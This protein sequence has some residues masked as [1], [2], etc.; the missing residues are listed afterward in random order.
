MKLMGSYSGLR[1]TAAAPRATSTGDADEWTQE[2][3]RRFAQYKTCF[4]S[5]WT[6]RLMSA[7]EFASNLNE[8][9]RF[10]LHL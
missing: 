3:L 7:L 4:V 8:S 9:Y 2:H 5:T 1:Q 10:P 6:Q